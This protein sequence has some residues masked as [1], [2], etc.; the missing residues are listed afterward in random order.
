V[1]V[2]VDFDALLR[3]YV[4]TGELCEI[5]GYGPVAV[6]AVRD[7][8]ATA[9]PFLVALATR[10]EQVT[11]VARLARRPSAAQDAA[12]AWSQ[13]GC[14]VAGCHRFR[15]LERDHRTPWATTRL[16]LLEDLDRLCAHHH[17]LKTHHGFELVAGPGGR[18]LVAPT[19]PRHPNKQARQV[20]ATA[21]PAP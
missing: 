16:T 3:G 11:G 10:G 5:A 17:S 21:G 14:A 13:P 6:A 7:L 18:E 20:G 19:D 1:L 15:D 9:N 2:R 12:L 4:R 8:I